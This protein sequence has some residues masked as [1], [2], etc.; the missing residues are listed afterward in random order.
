MLFVSYAFQI[1]F[2][3]LAIERQLLT[4]L[5]FSGIQM[6]GTKDGTEVPYHPTEFNPVVNKGK[7]SWFPY[8]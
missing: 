7:E 1:G 5:R 2:R 6:L 3:L 8:A 4:E